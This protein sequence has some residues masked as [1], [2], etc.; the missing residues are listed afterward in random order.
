MAV[1][2]TNADKALKSLYLDVV[3][4]QLNYKINPL[5]LAR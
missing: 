4:E 3:S 2:I 5:F 1:T